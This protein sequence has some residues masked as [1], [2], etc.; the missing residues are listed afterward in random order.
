VE[1]CLY[2][3]GDRF[4]APSLDKEIFYNESLFEFVHDWLV[5]SSD[6]ITGRFTIIKT[7]DEY[8]LIFVLGL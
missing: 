2:L 3:S 7:L 6:D 5:T 1:G 4:V 8:I